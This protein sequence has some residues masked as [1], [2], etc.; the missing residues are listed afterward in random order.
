MIGPLEAVADRDLAGGEVDQPAGNE[1][2]ADAPRA[3]LEERD[4]GIVD[5]ADAADA[6]TDE[7]AGGALV[8]IGRGMPVGVVERLV[9]GGHRVDD[10]VV[11]LAAAPSAPS[12]RRD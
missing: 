11:D 3:A 5:A 9:G 10:E 2:R 7:H 8:L 1:E 12:T 4:R 6:R